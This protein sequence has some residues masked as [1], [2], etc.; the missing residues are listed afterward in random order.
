M[1]HYDFKLLSK[2]NAQDPTNPVVLSAGDWSE[3]AHN[4]PKEYTA[5]LDYLA[6]WTLSERS[7][8]LYI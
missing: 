8:A 6:I 5:L 2:F 7:L 4:N 1:L 3:H